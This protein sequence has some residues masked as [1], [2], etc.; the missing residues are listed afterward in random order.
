MRLWLHHLLS[1]G[2]IF[3]TCE[4]GDEQLAQAISKDLS[5]PSRFKSKPLLSKSLSSSSQHLTLVSSYIHWD[6]NRA[7]LQGCCENQI[8]HM[9]T[10]LSTEPGPQEAL[11]KHW[12][13]SPSLSLTSKKPVFQKTETLNKEQ[14]ISVQMTSVVNWS[15]PQMRRVRP[16]MGK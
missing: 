16:R 14:D 3:P 4:A 5:R 12:P 11:E 7:Y 9:H 10:S 15:I 8:R 13:S 1:L 2:L 6:N